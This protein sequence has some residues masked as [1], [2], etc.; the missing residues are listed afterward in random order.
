M[1]GGMGNLRRMVAALLALILLALPQYAAVAS[2]IHACSECHCLGHN[3]V[4]PYRQ[5]AVSAFHDHAQPCQHSGGM[6]CAACCASAWCA[7]MLAL[8]PAACAQSLEKTASLSA[9]FAVQAATDGIP[10]DPALRPPRSAA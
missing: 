7:A 9:N 3:D 1:P 6:P 10:V 8:P 4:V 5:S 2:T